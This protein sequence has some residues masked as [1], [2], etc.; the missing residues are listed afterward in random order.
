[1]NAAEAGL[2]KLHL[3]FI[4]LSLPPSLH[5]ESRYFDLPG[6]RA[7]MLPCGNLQNV[8]PEVVFLV[9]AHHFLNFE[10]QF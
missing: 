10:S 9:S 2:L 6:V 5:V 1:M 4:I 3:S 7:E 8:K